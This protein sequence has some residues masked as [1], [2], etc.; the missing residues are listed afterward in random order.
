MASVNGKVPL[1][2]GRAV[3]GNRRVARILAV[4]AIERP[5]T[6]AAV[7]VLVAVALL[8]I[9][10]D[11]LAKRDIDGH[12]RKVPRPIVTLNGTFPRRPQ[13]SVRNGLDGQ[14]PG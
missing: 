6:P 11:Q 8:T 7:L 10:C 14:P 1:I 2:T 9:L 4:I 12:R 3:G 13:E 5:I